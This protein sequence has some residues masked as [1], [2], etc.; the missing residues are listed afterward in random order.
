METAAVEKTGQLKPEAKKNS[1]MDYFQAL[2]T[3]EKYE[4]VLKKAGTHRMANPG[5]P[6]VYFGERGMFTGMAVHVASI[7]GYLGISSSSGTLDI[8]ILALWGMLG[9]PLSMA[10]GGHVGAKRPDM[11]APFKY[12]EEIMKHQ[13]DMLFYQISEEA[14][15]SIE[16]E[17]LKKTRKALKI[18]NKNLGLEGRQMI[19]SSYQG[20]EG[21]YIEQSFSLTEIDRLKLTAA[22]T[23]EQKKKIAEIVPADSPAMKALNA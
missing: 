21:F 1:K 8:F 11:L 3:I 14:Y 23:P 9:V 12:R 15:A 10:I 16:S 6:D 13:Q 18:I 4:E 19:Y 22:A 2:E 5:S 7:A 17:V 20:H